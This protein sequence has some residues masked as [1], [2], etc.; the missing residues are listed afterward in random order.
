MKKTLILGAVLGFLLPFSTFAASFETNVKYGQRGPAVI[1][2]QEFLVD[3]GFLASGNA[4][5]N[6]YSL[7]LKAVK[8]YQAAKNLPA[9]GFWGPMT[10]AQAQLEVDTASSDEAEM[11][12][13]GAISSPV[14]ETPQVVQPQYVAAAPVA[15]QVVQAPVSKKKLLVEVEMIS[16][17]GSAP[18]TKVWNAKAF[19]Y[20]N[21]GSNIKNIEVYATL[22]ELMDETENAQKGNKR[23]L[24]NGPCACNGQWGYTVS[25]SFKPMDVIIFDVPEL[26]LSAEA[27]VPY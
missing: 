25:A 9:T 20:G 26:G 4:T 16:A 21:T 2:V 22:P 13:T 10:R 14:V 17:K 24:L 18:G 1:E 23:M 6:F 19:V 3:Q 8:A 15:Q 5:G 7:T 27:K 12:E 11:T